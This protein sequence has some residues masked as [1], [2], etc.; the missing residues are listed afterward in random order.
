[1]INRARL[2]QCLPWQCLKESRIEPDREAITAALAKWL[3]TDI[4]G[5]DGTVKRRKTAELAES[6]SDAKAALKALRR[7]LKAANLSGKELHIFDTDGEL[8]RATFDSLSRRMEQ[9]LDLFAPPPHPAG[10][11]GP[12]QWQRLVMRGI[13]WNLQEA[14]LVDW[15][16]VPNKDQA[17][18]MSAILIEFSNTK[19]L[20]AE[21]WSAEK[22]RKSRDGYFVRV[23]DRY[24]PP[25][26]V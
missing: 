25:E 5:N 12:D 20:D 18:F 24:H 23:R 21:A 9:S 4:I 10:N 16:N 17:K 26:F 13:F 11:T 2:I 15:F 3:D 1:M 7:H 8:R 19:G 22:W 14:W 6:F